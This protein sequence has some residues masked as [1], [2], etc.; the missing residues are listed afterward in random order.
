MGG[1]SIRSMSSGI[2]NM[3]DGMVKRANMVPGYLNRV[4]YR[5]YQNAQRERW[6]S[7]N[8]SQDFTGGIWDRLS[9]PYQ[10]YK[11]REFYDYPGAG[12]KILIATNRLQKSV[13]GPSPE[14]QKIVTDRAIKIFTTVPY[15][16]YVDEKRTFTKFSQIFYRDVFKGLKDYL[17]RDIIRSIQ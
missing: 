16:S 1:A 8:A 4:V 3:L 13:I 2:E 11:F 6:T 17:A 15:A 14:H 12:S 7:E 9:I 5:Q 10:E